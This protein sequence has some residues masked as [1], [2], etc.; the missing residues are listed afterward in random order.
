MSNQVTGSPRCGQS[1]QGLVVYES[2]ISIWQPPNALATSYSSLSL[3][4]SGFLPFPPHLGTTSIVAALRKSNSNQD[5][6]GV[7]APNTLTYPY[8]AIS[9]LWERPQCERVNA[10]W[11]RTIAFLSRAGPDFVH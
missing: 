6:N 10:Y 2:S 7:G 4:S 3:G 5:I 8:L 9:S 11:A 1:F